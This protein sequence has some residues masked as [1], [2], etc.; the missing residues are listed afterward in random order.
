M[1]IQIFGIDKNFDVKKTER[2]FKERNIPVQMINL[3]EKGISKGE[4]DSVVSCLL[5]TQGSMDKVIEQLIDKD[6]KNYSQI[7]YID[8]E[9]KLEK[10]LENPLLLK[11][12][13]VRNSK[14]TAT[15]GYTPEIWKT[16]T[17]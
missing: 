16:W 13:I 3:K 17:I 15:V 1:S 10:L 7:A 9:D 8:D 5:K 11:M 14:V 12:P 2:W 6:N 4:L